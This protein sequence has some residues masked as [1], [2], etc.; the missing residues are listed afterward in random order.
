VTGAR[1]LQVVSRGVAGLTGS[2][3]ARL[4]QPWARAP[5]H[6]VWRHSEVQ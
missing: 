6:T 4:M 2:L 1:K 5:I 3:P